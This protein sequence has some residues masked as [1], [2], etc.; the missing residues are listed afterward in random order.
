MQTGC[1]AS[2]HGGAI[3]SYYSGTLILSMSTF[4]NCSSKSGTGGAISV[5]GVLGCCS[6]QNNN[7]L[8]CTTL[9][10]GG[11]IYVFTDRMFCRSDSSRSGH[12]IYLDDSYNR[13][14]ETQFES[15]YSTNLLAQRLCKDNG[16][17]YYFPDWLLSGYLFRYVGTEGNDNDALCGM[18]STSSCLTIEKAIEL[19]SSKGQQQLLLLPGVFNP[20]I[21]VDTQDKEILITETESNSSEVSSKSLSA[22]SDSLFVLSSGVMFI[23]SLRITHFLTDSNMASHLF[24][25]I[26]QQ[27]RLVLRSVIISS[28]G[29][30]PSS[31]FTSSLFH[32]VFS[33]LR[34]EDVMIR[35]FLIETSL[36][37][38]HTSSSSQLSMFN[39]V[40]FQQITRTVGNGTIISKILLSSEQ[41]FITNTTLEDCSCSSGNG[42]G[43]YLR[44]TDATNTISICDKGNAK[45]SQCSVPAKRQD[46]GKGGGMYI[47]GVSDSWTLK[48]GD[49]SFEECKAWKGSHLFVEGSNLSE[50]VNKRTIGFFVDISGSSSFDELSGFENKNTTA[51]IPLVLFLRTFSAPAFVSGLD[52]GTDYRLCGYQDYPCSSIEAACSNRFLSQKHI[53][54]LLNSYVFDDEIIFDKDSNEIDVERVGAE[55]LVHSLSPIVHNAIVINK[56]T[57]TIDNITF[58]L[59]EINGRCSFIE[60]T[61]NEFSLGN[62]SLT[63]H[64]N[65]SHITYSFIT[66]SGGRICVQH[67]SSDLSQNML[68]D[69]KGMI[70][71]CEKSGCTLI[72]V[73]LSGVLLQNFDDGVIAASS[74]GS[75]V[76]QNCSF[77]NSSLA[78]GGYIV[79]KSGSALTIENTTFGNVTRTT[80]NGSCVEFSS[81][82]DSY[83]VLSISNSTFANCKIRENKKGGGGLYV[84]L[85]KPTQFCL[86][87]STIESCSAPILTGTE[88]KGGGM[89]IDILDETFF[90]LSTLFMDLNQAEYGNDLFIYSFDLSSSANELVVS[91]SMDGSDVEVCGFIK[92]PCQSFDFSFSRKSNERKSI[93][94]SRNYILNESLILDDVSGYSICGVNKTEL[95]LNG[96][97]GSAL[98]IFE[99]RQIVHIGKFAILLKKHIPSPQK[100]AIFIS[101]SSGIAT[102]EDCAVL[103]DAGADAIFF[104]FL[105]IN[106]GSLYLN[107]FSTSSIRSESF[108][109][110]SAATDASM[111]ICDATFVNVSSTNTKGLLSFSSCFHISLNSSVANASSS[112]NCGMIWIDNVVQSK[113]QNCSF[114]EVRKISGNGSALSGNVCNGCCLSLDSNTISACETKQGF[115]GGISV[116]LLGGGE[117]NVGKE[118]VCYIERSV[119]EA[120]EQYGGYGGGLHICCDESGHDFFLSQLTFGSRENTLNK[121][122]YG[123]KNV[124][125]EGY[126]L[127]ALLDRTSF[128]F[129][130][131]IEINKTDI[132]ELVG[133][134]SVS[135][136]KP[137]PLV[138]FFRTFS[139]PAMLGNPGY[140][141]MQCG[142]Y[143]YPCSTIQFAENARFKDGTTSIKLLP[144]FHFDNKLVLNKQE[145]VIDS[146]ST[147]SKISV[148]EE[149]AGLGEGLIESEVSF[150]LKNISFEIPSSLK[151]VNESQARECF[152]LCKCN[153][154]QL[155]ECSISKAVNMLNEQPEFFFAMVKGGCL[156]VNKL[157]VADIVFRGGGVFAID[158]TNNEDSI[159][160]EWSCSKV[161]TDFADGSLMK[162]KKGKSMRM[163]N[164]EFSDSHSED[165]CIIDQLNECSLELKNVSF[166]DIKRRNG[167]GGILIGEIGF[168]CMQKAENCT[169]GTQLVRNK[170]AKEA[171]LNSCNVSNIDGCG[172]GMHVEFLSSDMKYSLKSIVWSWN[173]GAHGRDLFAVCKHPRVVIIASL[174]SDTA[175][176]DEAESQRDRLWVVDEDPALNVDT[177]LFD[178]LFPTADEIVFVNSGGLDANVCGY[179]E[180]PCDTVEGGFNVLGDE[181]SIIQ[182]KSS[183]VLNRDLN[184]GQR[185]LTIRGNK[186]N[187]IMNIGDQ[188]HLSLTSGNSQA[189]LTLWKLN[190]VL[191]VH[192]VRTEFIDI[193]VGTAYISECSFGNKESSAKETN[194]KL[195]LVRGGILQISS[196]NIFNIHFLDNNT[197]ITA[198]DGNVS[199]ENCHILKTTSGGG[200]LIKGVENSIFFVKGTLAEQCEMPEGRAFVFEENSKIEIGGNCTFLKCKSANGHGGAIK[201]SLSSSCIFNIWNST[202]TGCEVSI[203]KRLYGGGLSFDLLLGYENSFSLSSLMFSLNNAY[204]GKDLFVCCGDLNESITPERFDIILMENGIEKVDFA[205]TDKKL[206]I[207]EPIDLLHLL[208]KY[209]G[210]FVFIDED[211]IDILGCG[212]EKLPCRSMNNGFKHLDNN[213]ISSLHTIY[214]TNYGL[215]EESSLT[216]TTPQMIQSYA[217]S[218]VSI[219]DLEFSSE[220]ENSNNQSVIVALRSLSFIRLNMILPQSF[221]GNQKE[222]IRSDGGS[223]DLLTCKKSVSTIAR[224]MDCTRPT[225]RKEEF[226]EILYSET[227][228]CV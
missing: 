129:N 188:G 142:Y 23:D 216:V 152:L 65:A 45:F 89:M 177:S 111:S 17:A 192:S 227:T 57:T 69:S 97:E 74:S 207:S 102:I 35:N 101:K 205:G 189:S 32:I 75:V 171:E 12:D 208:V 1:Y 156:I 182:I 165:G 127:Q 5:E 185:K 150:L 228:M 136:I 92:F 20:R 108:S 91:T 157:I 206:F 184:R 22:S 219:S 106:A 175:F 126:S 66:A 195:F 110:I 180:D 21:A 116:K 211:G 81:T 196:V 123:G 87:A 63:Q 191:P 64:S 135:H 140:D 122:S 8:N 148:N 226:S 6:V 54:R 134:E 37:T 133:F 160:S 145:T 56:V 159:I 118:S 68:F 15:C 201:C 221:A 70:N 86:V 72:D 16:T 155:V 151:I 215:F 172:G 137:I 38:E 76:I 77:N 218:D 47:Q 169:F 14:A 166:R 43:M 130:F 115:G 176:E 73:K 214:I 154:L 164:C 88:G 44:S 173:S 209:V 36:F 225:V 25:M 141:Y 138:L 62:C 19:S 42:G 103:C 93:E 125:L 9:D 49:V 60:T 52:E 163:Q 114:N 161:Q 41:F 162:L 33:Q 199:L 112:P 178:Y 170:K 85:K 149:G 30:Q 124:F 10:Y 27:G 83:Q 78:T 153:T 181:Q 190:L 223:I 28:Q 11:G 132:T 58:V 174:W 224:L 100:S 95:V 217:P 84:M 39:N 202:I 167:N 147:G 197:V 80:G 204:I 51:A 24:S 48:F 121:A 187:I 200:S 179:L 55:I 193:F 34:F 4:E 158:E 7:C 104:P 94:V 13:S 222:V 128:G 143:D 18:S 144:S 50:L 186:T 107:R 203:N 46:R 131:A 220:I 99:I 113:L 96:K 3:A 79:S 82:K 212:K 119:A 2:G 198:F 139:P 210:D 71:V 40:S 67:F 53:I 120:N 61:M 146:L 90:S 168:E 31:T 117:F 213:G 194:M 105:F 59:G 26:S 109:F 183:A 29:Q 98:G